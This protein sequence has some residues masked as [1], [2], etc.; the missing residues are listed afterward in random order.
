MS[1]RTQASTIVDRKTKER[2]KKYPQALKDYYA[3]LSLTKEPRT[4]ENYIISI[5]NMTNYFTDSPSTFDYG[6]I[7]EP[8]ITKYISSI[9]YKSNSETKEE[10]SYSY[11]KTVYSALKSFFTYMRKRRLISDNPMD[12]IERPDKNDEVKRMYLT[13]SDLKNILNAIKNGTN[14]ANREVNPRIIK[15]N[16]AIFLLF[17]TTGMREAA[18]A[19]IDIE[20]INFKTKK[21]KVIDKGDKKFVY[22]LDDKVID[23]IS[24]WLIERNLLDLRN[25]DTRALFISNFG[26]RLS[27]SSINKMIGSYSQQALGYA[28]SPHKLRAAYCTLY[29]EATHD[30]IKV[31]RAVKHA[32]VTTTQKYIVSNYNFQQEASDIIMN[33]VQ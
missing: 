31:Q 4:C 30:I 28:I 32:S 21:L 17:I 2:I 7:K 27:V 25:K 23:A 20:D 9:K 1:G 14:G 15:R 22:D 19:Q 6:T 5:I 10:T 33:S 24:D 8:Q 12:L 26:K 13:G 29:Y 11:R 3:N 18:L 16:I